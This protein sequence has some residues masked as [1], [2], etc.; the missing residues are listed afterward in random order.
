MYYRILLIL[1]LILGIAAMHL[2]SW[3]AGWF[4]RTEGNVAGLL[5]IAFLIVLAQLPYWDRSSS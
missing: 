2:W 1:I 5:L 4:V 3:F